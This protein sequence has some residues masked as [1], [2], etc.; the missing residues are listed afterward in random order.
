MQMS[1]GLLPQKNGGY[2][3]MPRKH[4]I[5]LFYIIIKYHYDLTDLYLRPVCPA[6]GS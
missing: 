1:S 6:Q 3:V 2:L 5:I 4:A